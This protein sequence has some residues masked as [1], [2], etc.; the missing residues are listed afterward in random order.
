MNK[1]EKVAKEKSL[2]CIFWTV[3]TSMIMSKYI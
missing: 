2:L 1:K 3:I